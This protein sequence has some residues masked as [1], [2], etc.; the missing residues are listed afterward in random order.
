MTDIEWWEMAEISHP[1]TVACN[2]HNLFLCA[3][4]MARNEAERISAVEG[5]DPDAHRS[6]VFDVAVRFACRGF[7]AGFRFRSDGGFGAG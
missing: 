4:H 6:P 2:I 1:M 5:A 7:R 3:L